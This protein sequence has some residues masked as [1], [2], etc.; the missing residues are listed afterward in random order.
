[1]YLEST[2]ILDHPE[3]KLK[4]IWIL[5]HWQATCMHLSKLI[6]MCLL[7]GS[8]MQVNT[9]VSEYTVYLS[10]HLPQIK[11]LTLLQP[12]IHMLKTDDIT[13]TTTVFIYYT[14]IFKLT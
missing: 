10:H 6:A 7:A 9:F 5:R 12:K 14:P 11:L 8:N 2:E 13:L 3:I 4:S 1:M